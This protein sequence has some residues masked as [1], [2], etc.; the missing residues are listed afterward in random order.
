MS[1]LPRPTSIQVFCG[2]P[3]PASAGTLKL[4]KSHVGLIARTVASA[5]GPDLTV[6][7]FD[8]SLPYWLKNAWLAGANIE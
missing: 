7:V 2:L 4:T 1:S 6:V 3:P 5:H 8:A